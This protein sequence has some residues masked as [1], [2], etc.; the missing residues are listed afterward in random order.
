MQITDSLHMHAWRA[1]YTEKSYVSGQHKTMRAPL[2]L[3]AIGAKPWC[4]QLLH[5]TL[6]YI[7]HRFRR[8]NT[9]FDETG[10]DLPRYYM[11][12]T[13]NVCIPSLQ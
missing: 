3:G 2:T 5:C 6:L 1:R 11:Y 10:K 12:L 9:E 13:L 4:D 8:V 7:S